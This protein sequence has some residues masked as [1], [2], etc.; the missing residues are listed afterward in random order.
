MR[1][2][3]LGTFAL[4]VLFIAGMTMQNKDRLQTKKDEVQARQETIELEERLA[5]LE[6]N[7]KAYTIAHDQQLETNTVLSVNS[8]HS[9]RR[10]SILLV[11]FLASHSFTR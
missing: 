7:T 9:L 11:S 4:L 3:E 8:L 10:A 2:A 5:E 1:L 6:A